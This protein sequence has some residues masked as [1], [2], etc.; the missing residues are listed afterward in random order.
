MC[1]NSITASIIAVAGAGKKKFSEIKNEMS[2]K[3]YL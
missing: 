1:E 3:I 2:E